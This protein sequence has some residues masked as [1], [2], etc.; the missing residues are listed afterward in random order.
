MPTRRRNLHMRGRR[1]LVGRS[2]LHARGHR[3]P[4]GRPK[5][6]KALTKIRRGSDAKVAFRKVRMRKLM[7]SLE[8]GGAAGATLSTLGEKLRFE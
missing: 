1:A 2:I 7:H 4:T 3:V 8:E 6:H 5:S